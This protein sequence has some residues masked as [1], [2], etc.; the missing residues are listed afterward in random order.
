MDGSV[1]AAIG[2]LTSGAIIGV[3][4]RFMHSRVRAT[5]GHMTARKGT[6]GSG[7]HKRTIC[8][9]KGV[10]PEY[11][12]DCIKAAMINCTR[13]GRPILL[14][15]PVTLRGPWRPDERASAWTSWHYDSD[16]F[17]FAIGCDYPVCGA[18]NYTRGKWVASGKKKMFTHVTVK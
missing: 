14:G 16:D 6:L 3:W 8:F 15:D 4:H 5:C 2:G 9:E 10:Q 12:L 7:E 17:R 11:C 13:C 1:L 18:G